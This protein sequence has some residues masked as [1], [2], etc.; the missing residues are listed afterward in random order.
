[1]SNNTTPD[2][3]PKRQIAKKVLTAKRRYFVPEH[4]MSVEAD[5]PAAAVDEAIKAR[6]SKKVKEGDG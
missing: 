1:M 6:K 4:G 5:S 2:E 3:T